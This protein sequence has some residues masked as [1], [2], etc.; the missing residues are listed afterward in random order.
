MNKCTD[1]KGTGY[2]HSGRI[3]DHMTPCPECRGTGEEQPV[4][5]PP[6]QSWW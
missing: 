4:V 1:C 6:E 3:V 2:D 5:K